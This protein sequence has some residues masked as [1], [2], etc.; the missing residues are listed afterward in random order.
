MRTKANKHSGTG[1]EGEGERG[2]EQTDRCEISG[3]GNSPRRQTRDR[4]GRKH[5]LG[6]HSP[7]RVDSEVEATHSGAQVNDAL[8]Q[9]ARASSFAWLN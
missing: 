2:C 8:G 5:S 7:D 1:G 9:R 6:K 3:G 4:T